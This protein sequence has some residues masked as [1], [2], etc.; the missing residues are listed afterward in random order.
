VLRKLENISR[1][2]GSRQTMPS[3]PPRCQHRQRICCEQSMPNAL[4]VRIFRAVMRSLVQRSSRT[5]RL[6]F[7]RAKDRLPPSGRSTRILNVR[8]QYNWGPLACISAQIASEVHRQRRRRLVSARLLTT[9][10]CALLAFCRSGSALRPVVTGL[11]YPNPGRSTCMHADHLCG[12][13]R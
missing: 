7:V 6:K 5:E 13:L 1:T 12:W 11:E 3:F 2:I 10:L 9:R 8:A 4:V